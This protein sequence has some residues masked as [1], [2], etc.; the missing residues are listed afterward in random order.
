MAGGSAASRPPLF[1]AKTPSTAVR[2]LVVAV[3]GALA[4]GSAVAVLVFA[5]GDSGSEPGATDASQCVGLEAARARACYT[6]AFTATIDGRDDPRPAVATI[7]DS[8]WK[9]GGFLLTNCH[10]IMHTVG[11]TY[12]GRAGV[13]VS[14]LMDYLPRSNDPGCTAGFAHGLVTGVAPDIDARRPAQA[15]KVC[16]NAGTRYQ[17]YS[18][19]HGFGHAFMRI[20]DDRLTPALGLCRRL[21]PSAAADCAQGAYHDYWF[22]VIGADDAKLSEEAV[23]DPRALCGAQPRV[24]VRPCWYRAFVDN[25]PEGFQVRS[26]RDLDTMCVGLEGL[27][28]EA[29]MTAASVIGPPDPALQLELCSDL[30]DPSDAA[31]CV[32]GTKVQNLLGYPMDAF[33]DLISRCDLVRAARAACY[34]WLGKT[35]AVL[36]DGE[37][38]R[39]GCARLEG[40]D[41]RRQCR[42]GARTMD[43]ALVTFS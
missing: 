16:G 42:F 40:A 14:T 36:T 34:H 28:R 27:Q 33:V 8:A 35:L 37:F 31:S 13:S 43:E 26:P 30:A 5:G 25:R 1:M 18:C 10:G 19:T 4:V 39:A 12:A 23:T 7:A 29:C 3:I 6:R 15:A 11:R 9:Q 41:A 22:A 32:R 24:F 21:G 2:L 17:R 38:E 20:F